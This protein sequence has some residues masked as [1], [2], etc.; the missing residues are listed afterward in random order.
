[1]SSLLHSKSKHVPNNITSHCLVEGSCDTT[2]DNENMKIV[3]LVC[4]STTTSKL[5]LLWHY[6]PGHLSSQ[7]LQQVLQIGIK[8]SDKL[9]K[10]HM[11]TACKM[12][13]SHKLHFSSSDTI[14]TTHFQ[15]IHIDIWEPAPIRLN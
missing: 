12:G 14:Y 2:L 10:S 5:S 9:S 8:F 11:C 1:M 3:N 13:K 15:P 6:R 7:I 4:M